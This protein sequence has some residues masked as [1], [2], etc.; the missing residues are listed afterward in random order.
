MNDNDVLA[1]QGRGGLGSVYVWASG[2]GGK[3]ADS[4]SCDGYTNSIWT[5][6]VSSA[7]Q[8]G[9]RPWYLEECPST[10]ATTY[11]SGSAM[12]PSIVTTDLNMPGNGMRACTNKH[13]GTSASAPLAAGIIALALEANPKLNWRDLQYLTIL[14]ARPE[15][16]ADGAWTVNGV[17]RKGTPWM[18][19][20]H[21]STINRCPLSFRIRF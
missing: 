21:Q 2:N 4:C 11:S 18:P 1:W 16:L 15:P 20:R 6:S 13:T 5:I 7:A 14:S 10:L 8:D 19:S 3:S 9:S 17:G 12:Q